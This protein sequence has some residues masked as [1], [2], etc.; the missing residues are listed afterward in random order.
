MTRSKTIEDI[1]TLVHEYGHALNMKKIQNYII[2]KQ[3]HTSKK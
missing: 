3:E 2:M 1:F